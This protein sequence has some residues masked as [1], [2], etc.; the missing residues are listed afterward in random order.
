MQEHGVS[1]I[2]SVK[3][4]KTDAAVT[5]H[6]PQSLE[7]PLTGPAVDEEE[8]RVRPREETVEMAE[9]K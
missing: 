2:V 1:T 8:D 5:D 3:F 6:Q 7:T 9:A 4:H